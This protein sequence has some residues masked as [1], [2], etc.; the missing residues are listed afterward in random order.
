M[1]KPQPPRGGGVHRPRRFAFAVPGLIAY[2][3]LVLAP[4]ILSFYF[5]LTNRNLLSPGSEFVGFDNYVRLAA[6]ERFLSTFGFTVTLTAINL[7]GVNVVGLAVAL[8][9]NKVGRMFFALRLVFFIP[10]ALSGVIIAFLWSRILT[11][12][13]LLNTFLRQFGLEQFALSWLGTPL[14]AQASVI[15]VSAWQG[16][17]LCVVVYLAGL[18]TVSGDVLEAARLDGCGRIQAFRHVTWPYL[19]PSLT[20]NS[21]LLLINGFKSYDI[22][23]VLTGT[24]PGHA[25]TTVATEVIRVGFNLTRA[26]LASAMAIIMVVVVAGATLFLV[27]LLQRREVQS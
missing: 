11:D 9:V 13:G 17:S 14:T 8:L 3:A 23:I 27:W 15:L 16:L 19:A 6:D 21:T 1:S 2:S 4:L 24:G 20:I 12:S 18:Q 5:S 26:G 10:V 25:T 22:P 7:I